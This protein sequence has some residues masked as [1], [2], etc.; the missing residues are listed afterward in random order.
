MTLLVDADFDLNLI[1]RILSVRAR[2]HDAGSYA[3]GAGVDGGIDE[4]GGFGGGRGEG[5]VRGGWRGRRKGR[6]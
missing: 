1:V 6:R 5:V 3:R 4:R 2:S